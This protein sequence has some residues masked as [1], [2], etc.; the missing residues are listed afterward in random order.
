MTG[1]QLTMTSHYGSAAGLHL[2]QLLSSGSIS[3]AIDTQNEGHGQGVCTSGP[4]AVYGR[5]SATHQPTPVIPWDHTDVTSSTISG[6]NEGVL[7]AATPVN[8]SVSEA[9][10]ATWYPYIG[11]DGT[12]EIYFFTPACAFDATCGQRGAVDV[13][14]S[15]SGQSGNTSPTVTTV[16][17]EVDY[18]T[19]TLI[20]TGAINPVSN[21]DQVT[22][23]M[24]LSA[25]D[26]PQ[27][28]PGKGYKYYLVADKVVTV[29]KNT[30]GNG[31]TQVRLGS[32]MT[33]VNVTTADN[34]HQL[35]NYAIGYGL[36]EWRVSGDSN[37]SPTLDPTST[38]PQQIR[39]LNSMTP[40]DTTALSLGPIARISQVL[41]YND[42]AII[43]GQF[44][45][46]SLGSSNIMLIGAVNHGVGLDGTVSSILIDGQWLYAV[47]DFSQSSDGSALQLQGRARRSL[48]D[49]T[50]R[51]EQVP[52]LQSDSATSSFIASTNG[53]D[54]LLFGY[55]QDAVEFWYPANTSIVTSNMP[56]IA[57]NLACSATLSDGRLF[58]AGKITSLLSSAVSGSA[59]VNANGV[60]SAGSGFKLSNSPR[61][62]AAAATTKR[63]NHL[64]TS[65]LVESITSRLRRRQNAPAVPVPTTLPLT[66]TLSSSEPAILAGTHWHNASS[67]EDVSILGGRFV[68]EGTNV[69]NLGIL[70]GAGLQGFAGGSD[71]TTPIVQALLAYDDILW[72]GTQ[73]TAE[74]E[75][76]SVY[77]LSA[78][79]WT[80][81][82]YLNS[83]AVS[84]TDASPSVNSLT[85]RDKDIIVA[86]HFA[87]FAGVSGCNNICQWKSGSRQWVAFG[88]GV[89]GVVAAVDGYKV[90]ANM[91]APTEDDYADL[92]FFQTEL[93]VSR[94]LLRLQQYL[95]LRDYL[96]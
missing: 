60:Q 70:T 31:S 23:T 32:G 84:T 78:Q 85:L 86:G 19:N 82:T 55:E 22:V 73:S 13:H 56:L 34:T 43:A 5:S 66:G 17:Q 8:A 54:K 29:A 7:C 72:I 44:T 3:Y 71:R 62:I 1:F 38:V 69:Q 41:T 18:D 45:S 49:S 2:L 65:F 15:I 61:S 20:Y 87:S 88:N 28:A 50:S 21:N 80:T 40:L 16:N 77:D 57:G 25:T 14:V 27:L 51:W 33:S 53:G 93:L 11:Q 24:T 74:H 26:R 90:G 95:C 37:I 9:P 67:N 30:D 46:E 63:S 68:V 35:L 83:A 10:M 4:A 12:Y 91:S 79:R 48:V 81:D 89:A 47:G 92:V 96:G 39:S 58:V 59:L 64:D 94:W 52:G 42:T 75:A 36:F 6:T 76:L